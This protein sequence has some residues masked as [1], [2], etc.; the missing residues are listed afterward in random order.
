MQ[1]QITD[2]TEEV[3]GYSQ[4]TSDYQNFD[5]KY[6]NTHLVYREPTT[7]MTETL[8]YPLD[9]SVT[10]ESEIANEIQAAKKT[11][12]AT[13]ED[14][15]SEYKLKNPGNRGTVY[16]SPANKFCS[17]NK[18]AR[19]LYL[20]AYDNRKEGRIDIQFESNFIII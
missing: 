9:S 4:L 18:E 20:F 8:H 10:Y 6:I 12:A 1:F 19:E 14:K 15:M 5:F 2:Y 13:L 11:F 17:V 16:F 3:G 7:E